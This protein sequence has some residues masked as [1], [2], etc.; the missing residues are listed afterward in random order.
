M[1]FP[2]IQTKIKDHIVQSVNKQGIG[3]TVQYYSLLP[4]IVEKWVVENEAQL[5]GGE[6]TLWKKYKSHY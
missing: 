2:R 5:L 4:D 6:R 1:H 3:G